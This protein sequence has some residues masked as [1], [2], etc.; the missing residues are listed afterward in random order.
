MFY[1][2]FDRHYNGE[3]INRLMIIISDCGCYN[4]AFENIFEVVVFTILFGVATM[5]MHFSLCSY[6]IK[7]NDTKTQ[8][9]GTR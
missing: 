1:M 8:S 4:D 6:G 5:E 2:Y 9:S 7:K 3:F